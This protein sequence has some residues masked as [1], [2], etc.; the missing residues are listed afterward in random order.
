MADGD[1]L[2]FES[3][4]LVETVVEGN[5]LGIVPHAIRVSPEGELFIV[6]SDNSNIVRV[7]PP[8]SQCM[9]LY[10]F[11]SL[12]FSAIREFVRLMVL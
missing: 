2:E 3:G 7:T 9:F 4:Y 12:D 1:H 8:L 5:K 10:P 11:S 6:D